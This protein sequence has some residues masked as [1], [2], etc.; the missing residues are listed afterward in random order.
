MGT[1]PNKLFKCKPVKKHKILAKY[2][3]PKRYHQE[4]YF[5]NQEHDGS[6]TDVCEDYLPLQPG[7]QAIYNYGSKTEENAGKFFVPF[8]G[9]LSSDDDCEICL[10]SMNN[11]MEVSKITRCVHKFHTKCIQ[12]VCKISQRCPICRVYGPNTVHVHDEQRYSGRQAPEPR[13]VLQRDTVESLLAGQRARQ[14]R[15]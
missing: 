7:Q 5:F 11:G 8:S 15:P 3:A 9:E 4:E 13:R 1:K 14:P 6:W 12:D 10:Q 2:Y